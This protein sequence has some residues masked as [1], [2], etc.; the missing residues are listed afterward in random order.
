[1]SLEIT[2]P[3]YNHLDVTTAARIQNDGRP[4]AS[5]RTLA[6]FALKAIRAANRRR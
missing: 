2:I 5:A 3:G 1:M 4:E 6:N